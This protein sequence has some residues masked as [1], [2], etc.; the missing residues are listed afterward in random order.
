MSA[1]LEVTTYKRKCNNIPVL[2]RKLQAHMELVFKH[3]AV[4]AADRKKTCQSTV[5]V[6]K[7]LGLTLHTSEGTH[8]KIERSDASTK[9]SSK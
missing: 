9:T 2:C 4:K 3:F 6:Q 5:E 8:Q 7:L 1:A